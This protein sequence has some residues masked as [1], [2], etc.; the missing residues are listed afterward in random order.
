MSKP[1][2]YFAVPAYGQ[3]EPEV[4]F[5]FLRISQKANIC[6]Q[7]G[8]LSVLTRNFNSLWRDALNK[9]KELGITHFAMQHSDIWP[10]PYW[11]DILLDEMDTHGADIMAAIPAIKTEDQLTS[12]GW[13]NTTDQE[14]RRITLGELHAMPRETFNQETEG[15]V[16]ELLVF[17]TGL[18][19]CD[20]TKPWVEQVHF[21]FR[22][23][24]VK[25]PDGTF[26]DVGLS[27][28]WDFSLQA[29]KL[30]LKAFA[31][32]KIEIVHFGRKGYSNRLPEGKK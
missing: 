24:I 12:T 28:D 8:K 13:Y 26:L 23:D 9:R 14:V 1:V 18:W 11:M 32:W 15:K 30:G 4:G 2:V 17:N 20:F 22:D 29:H 7:P 6:F 27:E 16:D 10:E 31:T 25:Q 21:K 5:S 19:I 3:L